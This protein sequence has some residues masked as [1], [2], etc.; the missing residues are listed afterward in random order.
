MAEAH[1][2]EI[3]AEYQQ[4][5]EHQQQIKEID[6]CLRCLI[7]VNEMCNKCLVLLDDPFQNLDMVDLIIDEI[8]T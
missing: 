2:K 5:Y 7:M 6:E 1:R 3:I 8:D 4:D